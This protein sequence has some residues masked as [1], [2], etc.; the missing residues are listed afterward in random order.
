[1]IWDDSL[2]HLLWR[3][4]ASDG[5]RGAAGS[6]GKELISTL[7]IVPNAVRR[8]HLVRPGMFSRWGIELSET[9]IHED[10]FATDEDSQ[11]DDGGL[12]CLRYATRRQT[13]S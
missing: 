9:R 1:M 5:S 12:L 7:E 10:K 8:A 4:H 2:R 13:T 6:R 11:K 3:L